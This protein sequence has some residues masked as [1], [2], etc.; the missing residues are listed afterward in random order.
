MENRFERGE[1][2][3]DIGELSI[4]GA[5]GGVGG[6]GQSSPILPFW[7]GRAEILPPAQ[8][9]TFSEKCN[10][11]NFKIKTFKK[12]SNW[13]CVFIIYDPINASN[14]NNETD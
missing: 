10:G 7:K 1:M 3:G 14:N 2:V 8:I 4:E 9:Y 13:K 12:V 11:Q 5:R 6:G